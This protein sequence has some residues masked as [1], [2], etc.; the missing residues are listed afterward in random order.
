[1][2]F[3]IHEQLLTGQDRILHN[4]ERHPIFWATAA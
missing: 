4:P 1:V 2:I 3:G